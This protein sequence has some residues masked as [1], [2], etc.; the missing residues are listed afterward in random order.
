MAIPISV[1]VQ[2]F[3]CSLFK[4][5]FWNVSGFHIN[6]FLYDR[7]VFYRVIL[8]ERLQSLG[9]GAGDLAQRENICLTCTW[10]WI[11]S[12]ALWKSKP[13][14]NTK[15]E[16]KANLRICLDASKRKIHARQLEAQAI[17]VTYIY[18]L[19]TYV[20]IHVDIFF[21]MLIYMDSI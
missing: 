18:K 9:L 10:P 16:Q 21:N 5:K 13:E 3:S 15:T 20:H 6:L 8:K 4:F 7:L 12:T 2:H 11:Q 19:Y 1:M 17:S 14:T